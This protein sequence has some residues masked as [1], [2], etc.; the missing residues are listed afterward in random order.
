MDFHCWGIQHPEN[1]QNKHYAMMQH[2]TGIQPWISTAEAFHSETS[3]IKWCNTQLEYNGGLSLLQYS[4]AKNNNKPNNYNNY[5][6]IHNGNNS[7]EFPQPRHLVAQN[8]AKQYQS[9]Q[10]TMGILQCNYAFP[11][12]RRSTP[13]SHYRLYWNPWREYCQ[14]CKW[15]KWQVRRSKNVWPWIFTAE[16]W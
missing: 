14:K 9:M 12:L 7:H 2:L 11:L 16:V 8:R 1:K 3:T 6:T 13:W 15:L 4:A 5:E 10:H